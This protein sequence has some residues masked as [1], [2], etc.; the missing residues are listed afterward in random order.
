M[1]TDERYKLEC[2]KMRAEMSQAG[3][4]PE[5]WEYWRAA[6]DVALQSIGIPNGIAARRIVSR[7]GSFPRLAHNAPQP[8]HPRQNNDN[9]TQDD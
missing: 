5:L 9:N 7:F 4:K 3:L 8:A 6:S 2:A 1:T